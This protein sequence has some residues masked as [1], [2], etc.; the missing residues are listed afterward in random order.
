MAGAFKASQWT[1]LVNRAIK[2]EK[3]GMTW[4]KAFYFM[5]NDQTT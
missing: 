3:Q 2:E 1:S 4:I 5:V